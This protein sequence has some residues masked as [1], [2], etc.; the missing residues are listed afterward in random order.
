MT[1]AHPEISKP[2]VEI[3]SI[4]LVARVGGAPER[5]SSTSDQ[6]R[7]ELLVVDN[8][9][10]VSR[11]RPIMTGLRDQLEATRVAQQSGPFTPNWKLAMANFHSSGNWPGLFRARA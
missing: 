1:S 3:I 8:T 6:S 10:A 5:S 4:L 11:E 9:Q 2:R 7:E